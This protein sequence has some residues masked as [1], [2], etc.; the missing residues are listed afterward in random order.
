MLEFRVLSRAKIFF[1]NFNFLK[2]T[3]LLVVYILCWLLP[4]V[5]GK[6][7]LRVSK[8]C[9]PKQL[10]LSA[11]RWDHVDLRPWVYRRRLHNVC[12]FTRMPFKLPVTVCFLNVSFS[13]ETFCVCHENTVY[14]G[15]FT[16]SQLSI[17]T[18][19]HWL[20]LVIKVSSSDVL[21]NT[22]ILKLN[23]WL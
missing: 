6:A 19:C 18:F 14:A 4:S 22:S 3:V 8:N 15:Q 21:F 12:V 11:F 2:S 13:K 9:K 1:C 20:L 5:D 17:S 23:W 10:Y 16:S 7:S